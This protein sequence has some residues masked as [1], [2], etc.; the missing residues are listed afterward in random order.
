M[1]LTTGASIS[2]ADI[3][4]HRL[5]EAARL[6]QRAF[7]FS[8]L[9]VTPP[10]MLHLQQTYGGCMLGAF[11][12]DELVGFIPAFACRHERSLI[13]Y[14]AGLSVVPTRQSGGIGAALM[15]A[16]GNYGREQGYELI[17][18]TTNVV[19]SRNVYLYLNK[20]RATAVA[21]TPA[22]YVGLSQSASDE[23]FDG[24]DLEFD[25]HL[26][27]PPRPP[28]VAPDDLASAEAHAVTRTTRGANGERYVIRTAELDARSRLVLRSG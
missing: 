1:T 22:I 12:G 25:W 20:V 5:P 3:P 18:W 4:K 11:D 23:G 10:A 21:Y 8:D 24:D 15:E 26:S 9:D 6:S 13:L 17:K 16:M 7:G 27:R 28:D 19:D 2:I 14:S